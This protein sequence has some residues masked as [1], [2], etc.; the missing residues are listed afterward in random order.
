MLAEGL[1]DC[2]IKF[3]RERLPRAFYGQK[4]IIKNYCPLHAQSYK[5]FKDIKAIQKEED[6]VKT[7]AMT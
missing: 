4:A 7:E 2:P 6:R 3:K 5:M 1:P